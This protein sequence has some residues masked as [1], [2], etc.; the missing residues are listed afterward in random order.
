[1]LRR[2]FRNKRHIVPRVWRESRNEELHHLIARYNYNDEIKQD[3]IGRT[4]RTQ[5]RMHAR[6]C[7]K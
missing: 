3:E 6:F 2:I 7:W 4:C 1:V 5:R